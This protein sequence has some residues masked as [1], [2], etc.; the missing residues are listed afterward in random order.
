MAK[1]KLKVT[2]TVKAKPAKSFTKPKVMGTNN[3]A[4]SAAKAAGKY[5]S[6]GRKLNVNSAGNVVPYA[7][8]SSNP[9]MANAQRAINDAYGALHTQDKYLQGVR[10]R[11]KAQ[12]N[13]AYNSAA[14]N[15]YGAYMNSKKNQA[16]IASNYGM[17]GGA[18]ERMGV[19]NEAQFNKNT[20][21]NEA[22]RSRAH[23]NA[24]AEYMDAYNTALG[25]YNQQRQEYLY[26]GRLQ[27]QQAAE[28]K[29][30]DNLSVFA[31]TVGRYDTVKKAKKA[32]KKLKKTD[33]NYKEK[34]QYILAQ[35]AYIKAQNKK[36]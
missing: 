6:T 36:K 14:Q 26:Q 33:K 2:N 1:M 35:I 18:V 10:E 7:T 3:V 21:T 30:A 9:Y 31:A 20:A 19:R 34:R 24:D 11:A 15:A 23:A 22:V 29:Q 12:A 4:I 16:E 13:T 27:R 28:K 32:L 25:N 5:S 17:T 8:F